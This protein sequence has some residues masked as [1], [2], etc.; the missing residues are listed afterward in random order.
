MRNYYTSTELLPEL[1][2]IFL[3]YSTKYLLYSSSNSNKIVYTHITSESDQL[4]VYMYQLENPLLPIF[5]KPKNL[6]FT[7]LFGTYK[8]SN[9]FSNSIKTLNF[10]YSQNYYR[11]DHLSG[12][13]NFTGFPEVVMKQEGL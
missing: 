5:H 12:I 1:L 10:Q 3:Q 9:G 2:S 4:H 7:E 6:E 8:G 13:M 11:N